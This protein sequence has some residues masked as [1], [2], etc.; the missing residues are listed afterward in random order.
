M[1]PKSLD[2]S[3]WKTI[4]MLARPLR[5]RVLVVILLAALSTGASLVEPLIYRVVVNDIAGLF[6]GKAQSEAAASIDEGEFSTNTPE[7]AASP[8]P[9]PH[10]TPVEQHGRVSARERQRQI[11]ERTNERHRPGH[12]AP[13]T[14]D[15]TLRTFIW[16]V[17]LMFALSLFSYF[18]WLIADNMGANIASQIESGFIQRI[19]AHVLRLPLPFF[20]KRSSGAIAKQIDQADQVS[21]IVNA[22]TQTLLPEMMTIVGALAIMLTQSWEMTL[23]AVVTVPAYLF[24][25]WR[26]ARRLEK[27]LEDYYGQWE[28]VS[29]R[30]QDAVSAI[31]TVRLSGAENRE[32]EQFKTASAQA[33]DSYLKRTRLENKFSFWQHTITQLGHVLV[34]GLGGWLALKRELT[35]G[36][37][38]MFVA[39]VG[40]LYDPVDSLTKVA[41]EIQQS[42]IGLRRA[43]RLSQTEPEASGG[44]VVKPGPGKIEL[45]NVDFGYVPEHQVLRQLSLSIEPGKVVALVGPSGAGKTTIVDLLMRLYQPSAG[46][47]LLDGQPLATLDVAALRRD[48]GVVAADGAVFRGTLADNIRYKRPEATDAEVREAALASGLAHTLERLPNALQTTIGEG[49]MGLSVGERQRL[50]LARMLASAPRL[51]VLDEATANLDYATEQ[52]VKEALARLRQG[53]TTI[54][55]AHRYSMVKGV[56]YVYVLEDGNVLEAGT[57][58]ELITANGWFAAFAGGDADDE[59][60]DESEAEDDDFEV[61]EV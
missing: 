1:I 58:D 44:E 11:R 55:I 40:M 22:V 56:D 17:T 24:V 21:P 49:G 53:R 39:Y 45:Q 20:G 37:V 19:F 3:P 60:E 61:E 35:P 12:V 46:K 42:G 34:L 9:Q 29:G 32:I 13:R 57:P 27:G 2:V 54:V 48:I 16:A 14:P 5:W 25:A 23:I 31:K 28:D 47:I 15:Q 36:D 26:S 38:V 10:R 41:I 18:V 8:S 7:P 50:Q 59:D 30:I 4:L 6:V 51:I 43:L 52:Q 33:Y